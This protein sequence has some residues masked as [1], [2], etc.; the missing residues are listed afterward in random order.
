MAMSQTSAPAGRNSYRALWSHTAFKN[1]PQLNFDVPDTLLAEVDFKWLMAGQGW[2][3]D[4]TRFHADAAYAKRL[5]RA[6]MGSEIVALREC[7]TV[8]YSKNFFHRA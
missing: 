6:A 2:R 1:S 5:L 8:L 7:A 4:P 3:V